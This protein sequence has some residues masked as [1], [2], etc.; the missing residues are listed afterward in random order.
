[1]EPVSAVDTEQAKW[2]G[3]FAVRGS[4]FVGEILRIRARLERHAA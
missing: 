2:D 3:Q 1:L 4:L